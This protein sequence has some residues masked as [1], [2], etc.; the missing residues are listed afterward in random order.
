MDNINFCEPQFK[1][2]AADENYEKCIY[3]G[4]QNP[5]SYSNEGFCGNLDAIYDRVIKLI[6]CW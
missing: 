3:S 1:C 6:M 4:K 5:C 2:M